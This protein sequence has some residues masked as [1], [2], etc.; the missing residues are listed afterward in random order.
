MEL[1]RAGLKLSQLHPLKDIRDKLSET[2]VKLAQ[3]SL[4]ECMRKDT[5]KIY[6]HYYENQFQ[7][8]TL[9]NEQKVH[10]NKMIRELKRLG[11]ELSNNKYDKLKKAQSKLIKI[12]EEFNK[13]CSEYKEEHYLTKEEL[14]GMDDNWLELR[15]TEND[16]YKVSLS[17]PDYI[18]LMQFCN[19]RETR[20]RMCYAFMSKC[21]GPNTKLMKDALDIRK[22][23]ASLLGYNSY[24]DYTLENKMAKNEQTVNNFLNEL[25]TNLNES[26]ERDLK[27]IQALTDEKIDVY[28]INYY[29]RDTDPIRLFSL[30]S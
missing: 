5:Y 10:F 6:K 28:D 8:E 4:R 23:I 18:P 24:A 15:K 11:L 9:T 17:Y 12:Q 3:F 20:K 2:D 30:L 29:S 22:S 27:L 19:V 1:K 7:N 25:N 16:T 21:S 26:L 14:D 13:N